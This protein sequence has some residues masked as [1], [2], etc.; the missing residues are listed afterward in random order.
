MTK[1]RRRKEL[2]T[3]G[4]NMGSRD[5]NFAENLDTNYLEE[6]FVNIVKC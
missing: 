2:V 3:N 4:N 6:H 1:K 5:F